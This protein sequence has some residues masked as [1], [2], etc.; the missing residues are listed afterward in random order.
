MNDNTDPMVIPSSE[1]L[2]KVQSSGEDLSGKVIINYCLTRVLHAAVRQQSLHVVVGNRTIANRLPYGKISQYERARAGEIEVV[3]YSGPNLEVE[4]YR[5]VM[6]FKAGTSITLAVIS[7]RFG[8]E[9]GVI[10]DYECPHRSR[11]QSCLRAVNLTYGGKVFDI[12]LRSGNIAFCKIQPKEVTEWIQVVPG[13]Y[14]F[15]VIESGEEPCPPTMSET[16]DEVPYAPPGTYANGETV[17]MFYQRLLSN[18]MY[19]CYIIGGGTK[20]T[21][22]QIVMAEN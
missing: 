20:K 17:V 13:E 22:I 14:E 1:E 16:L 4:I 6:S 11:S 10:D 2:E 12:L 15:Y 18:T 3:V 8:V 21:P 7:T 9:I 5:A 19:T